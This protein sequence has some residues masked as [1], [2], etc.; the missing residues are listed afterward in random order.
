MAADSPN[1]TATSNVHVETYTGASHQ[2]WNRTEDGAFVNKNSTN[3]VLTIMGTTSGSSIALRALG[4][5]GAG[6]NQIWD[7]EHTKIGRSLGVYCGNARPT[8]LVQSSAEAMVMIH[9]SEEGN[10]GK[11]FKLFNQV[12]KFTK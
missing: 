10:Q 5:S 8:V 4:T 7:F 9:H 3:L 6:L 11:F 1:P 2:R 12:Y